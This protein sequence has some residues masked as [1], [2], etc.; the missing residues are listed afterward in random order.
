MLSFDIRSLDAK[1][2]T[3][4]G[5]LAPDDP[6]WQQGDP[7]PAGP[8]EVSGRLSAAGPGRYYWSGRL[9]GTAALSCRRCLEPVEVGVEEAA[10]MLFVEPGDE[11]ADDPDVFV[12]PPPGH[13]LDLRPAIREQWLVVAPA[14]AL[15]RDDCRGL[16][17]TCGTDL[18]TGACDCPSATDSRWDAIRAARPDSR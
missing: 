8:I 10:S 16:C 6:V 2:A 7:R 13:T 11:G 18:N 14:F 3:V 9:A 17:A 12:I 5:Q 1:A 15:C 4:E